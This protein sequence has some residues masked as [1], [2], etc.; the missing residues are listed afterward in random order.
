VATG[1]KGHLSRQCLQYMHAILGRCRSHTALVQHRAAILSPGPVPVMAFAARHFADGG[2]V[3]AQAARVAFE[4]LRDTRSDTRTAMQPHVAAAVELCRAADMRTIAA[5]TGVL[6][7]LSLLPSAAELI[8][9]AEGVPVLV[10][11]LGH[12]VRSPNGL[13]C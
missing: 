3:A 9:E 2:T 13:C 12:K 7:M 5:A 10:Q 6:W 1:D 11:L 4:L 8:V